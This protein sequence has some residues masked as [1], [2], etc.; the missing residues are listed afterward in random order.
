MIP[1][2]LSSDSQNR[3]TR[4]SPASTAYVKTLLDDEAFS[5]LSQLLRHASD[6]H[7][8]F[9]THLR[10]RRMEQLVSR[11]TKNICL[12]TYAG[13]ARLL[14]ASASELP[15]DILS[16]YKNPMRRVQHMYDG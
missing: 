15:Y 11:S 7:D 9:N 3:T 5:G 10:P 14:L 12:D 1:A 4:I 2:D 8:A 13:R 16:I 6:V